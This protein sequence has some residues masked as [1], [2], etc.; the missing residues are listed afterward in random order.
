L[1]PLKKSIDAVRKEMIDMHE[2]GPL[3]IKYYIEE[4][5]QLHDLIRKMLQTDGKAQLLMGDTLKQD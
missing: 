5:Q 1:A 4:N 2:R 3:L